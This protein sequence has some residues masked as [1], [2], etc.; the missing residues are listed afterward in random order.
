MSMQVLTLEG[1]VR[2]KDNIVNNLLPKY[3]NGFTITSDQWT[4]LT[5]TFECD[6]IK[7]NSIIDI[8]YNDADRSYVEDL[9]IEY[10]RGSGYIKIIA[11][12]KPANNIKVDSI[13]ITNP[14]VYYTES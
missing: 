8:Y 7:S 10:E 3:I 6:A 11:G 4:D 14:F 12:K 1:T 2:L 13:V 5:Y 9:N